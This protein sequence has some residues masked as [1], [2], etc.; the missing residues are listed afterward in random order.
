[1]NLQILIP[2]GAR[3]DE[4]AVEAV[5]QWRFQPGISKSDGQFVRGAGAG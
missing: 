2:V 5:N 1:M 3:L 4:K